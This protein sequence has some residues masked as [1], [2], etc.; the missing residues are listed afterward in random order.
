M[1]STNVSS[2]IL[3]NNTFNVLNEY[4]N[5]DTSDK[6]SQKVY[7]EL[8]QNN[9]I[10]YNRLIAKSA[11][12]EVLE[13]TS[14]SVLL[15]IED[16]LR[17]PH[18]DLIISSKHNDTI[19]GKS[20]DALR[21]YRL[22]VCIVSNFPVSSFVENKS[23]L[24]SQYKNFKNYKNI[25]CWN[26]IKEVVEVPFENIINN[27]FRIITVYASKNSKRVQSGGNISNE[28][29][30]KCVLEVE[31][32]N[33]DKNMS[34]IKGDNKCQ[35]NERLIKLLFGSNTVKKINNE[36]FCEMSTL[37]WLSHYLN[38]INTSLTLK[39]MKDTSLLQKYDLSNSDMKIINDYKLSVYH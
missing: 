38:K 12:L 27:D 31:Q 25:K 17:M 2:N 28:L 6:V 23:K 4:S 35:I 39:E 15:N 16:I 20:N 7:N 24:L 9:I 11:Q 3:S 30:K 13:E 19:N 5:V 14:G 32:T 34:S 21:F 22:Y 1:N 26:E 33:N 36:K 8:I 10:N 37:D 18:I 29:D